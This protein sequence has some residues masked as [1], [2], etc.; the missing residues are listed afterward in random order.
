MNKFLLLGAV[1]LV[2]CAD[3]VEEEIDTVEETKQTTTETETE[4]NEESES[5]ET[6]KTDDPEVVFELWY[7]P[8]GSSEYFQTYRAERLP[9]YPEKQ[10]WN[11][12]RPSKKISNKC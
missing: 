10:S 12:Q 3:T 9:L 5:E 4:N 7:G 1:L 11:K 6:T 8:Y 2:G